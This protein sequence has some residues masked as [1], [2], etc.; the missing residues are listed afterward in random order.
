V[1]LI[2]FELKNAYKESL[3]FKKGAVAALHMVHCFHLAGFPKG[4]ISCVT[5]KGSEIGDFLTMHPGVNCIR[6]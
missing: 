3:L 5:G 1:K 2:P 6:Y 4:L